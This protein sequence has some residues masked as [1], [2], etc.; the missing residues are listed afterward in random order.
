MGII[1]LMVEMVL[2]DGNV[3]ALDVFVELQA[4]GV[5]CSLDYI[6]N[7]RSLVGSVILEL[8]QQKMLKRKVIPDDGT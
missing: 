4:L 1:E 5:E 7:L 8:Q 3:P 2:E 6:K